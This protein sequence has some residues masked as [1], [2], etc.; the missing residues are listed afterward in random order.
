MDEK[1][2]LSLDPFDDSKWW[3]RPEGAYFKSLP[4]LER[5]KNVP[6]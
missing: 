3:I 6:F 2:W 5:I 4:I 1:P